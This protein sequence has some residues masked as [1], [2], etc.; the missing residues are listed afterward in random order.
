MKSPEET[1]ASDLAAQLAQSQ[2][3]AR[4]YKL[5]EATESVIKAIQSPRLLHLATHGFFFPDVELTAEQIKRGVSFKYIDNPM[6]RAGLAFSG[7]NYTWEHGYNPFEEEDGILTALEISNLD[8][9]NTKLVV[10][11]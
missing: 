10:T 7:A 8:L 4:Y 2:Q 3:T 9:S 5:A 1:P 11:P 6:F